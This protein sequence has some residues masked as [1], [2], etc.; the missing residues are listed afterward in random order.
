[1]RSHRLLVPHRQAG[2]TLVELVV[3]FL[4]LT[5]GMVAILELVSQSALNARYAKDRTIATTLAQQKLEELLSQTDL[6]TGEMEGDF[7]DAY[8]QFR[9]RAQVTDVSDSLLAEMGVSLRQIVVVVEWSD[10]R[11]VH[12]VQL[13]TM[14]ASVPLLHPQEATM[15]QAGSDLSGMQ[16]MPQGTIPFPSQ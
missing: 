13:E 9:W 6:T 2:F 3:A 15:Q 1:M 5:I 12:S 7:G 11:R 8:P 10:R 14:Q 16:G 4:I